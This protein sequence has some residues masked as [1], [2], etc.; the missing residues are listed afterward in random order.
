MVPNKSSMTEKSKRNKEN[1]VIT[2]FDSSSKSLEF[3]ARLMLINIPSFIHACSPELD[4]VC[5]IIQAYFLLQTVGLCWAMLVNSGF[6]VACEWASIYLPLS[7]TVEGANTVRLVA[8]FY[9]SYASFR[10]VICFAQFVS[11]SAIES[12][13]DFPEA[14]KILSSAGTVTLHL[15]PIIFIPSV[16]I[17]T[18]LILSDQTCSSKNVVARLFCENSGLRFLSS[19]YPEIQKLVFFTILVVI[20]QVWQ[21]MLHQ[22]PRWDK[23]FKRTPFL[24]SFLL[25]FSAVFLSS[26]SALVT[27]AVLL[28]R[29][30][31]VRLGAWSYMWP[32]LTQC[33]L[34]WTLWL[35]L[36]MPYLLGVQGK[37]WAT[38]VS[39]SS[40]QQLAAQLRISLV[41]LLIIAFLI[42]CVRDGGLVQ[43]QLDITLATCLLPAVFVFVYFVAAGVIQAGPR[44]LLWAV[45]VAVISSVLIFVLSGQGQSGGST[46][47]GSIILVAVH[48]LSKI[49]QLMGAGRGHGKGG[50]AD[51]GWCHE[52]EV[53]E[54]EQPP[55]TVDSSH[56]PQTVSLKQLATRGQGQSP[57]VSLGLGNGMLTSHWLS[58]A[59]RR[60]VYFLV[61]I[62]RQLI[63]FGPNGTGLTSMASPESDHASHPPTF[64]LVGVL[65]LGTGVAVSVAAI[66]GAVSVGSVLQQHVGFFPDLI[67]LHVSPDTLLFDHRVSNVTLHRRHP[68]ESDPTLLQP[69]YASCSWAWGGRSS[70]S[71]STGSK[72]SLFDLSLLAEVAYL[73]ERRELDK[74]LL[75]LFP[76]LAFD[77]VHTPA[78]RGEGSGPMY[79][80]AK[81]SVLGGT[82]L[83]IRGTD[84]GRLGDILEDA[85]LYAETVIFSL[86]GHVFLPMQ[87]WAES[88]AGAMVELLHTMTHFF[89]PMGRTGNEYYQPLAIRVL[90]LVSQG[91][92]VV[93]TGHSLG[94]GLAGV[95]GA[96]AG[97]T[98]VSFAGPGLA[99]SH[100]KFRVKMSDGSWHRVNASALHHRSVS[101]VTEL[102]W[103]P[104]LD[105]QVGLVQKVLCERPELAHLHACHVLE[106]TVCH[107]LTHCGDHRRRFSGCSFSYDL[108]SIL[109]IPE[110]VWGKRWLLLLPAILLGPLVL[111]LTVLSELL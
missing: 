92:E 82:V 20:V 66:L 15:S 96:I 16:L 29:L 88:T 48:L 45:P 53:L 70:E 72:L 60:Y 10:V 35:A 6:V 50:E 18:G 79:L 77:L 107:L 110:L 14:A 78:E 58:L 86:L 52:E 26:Y 57:L 100:R 4:R 104:L 89:T 22:F 33:L 59:S 102:D 37:E 74:A 27:T 32:M 12:M 97:V 2:F 44:L 3:W 17:Q 84:V 64:T 23:V 99:L 43:A 76:D 106:G 36:F 80:E 111:G 62:S 109:Y 42:G 85:R 83:A 61:N 108:R 31:A 51:E 101:V 94:G 24:L 9:V 65:R 56:I 90:E 49:I 39:Q 1:F 7:S 38:R 73:S 5:S 21:V 69:S 54:P 25:H 47:R 95:V 91:E 13:K 55:L 30:L 93:I 40:L 34:G 67:D 19:T 81:S 68:L 105:R 11:H 75:L 103:I 71:T 8:A 28:E 98:S 63:G 41:G 46:G 87:L